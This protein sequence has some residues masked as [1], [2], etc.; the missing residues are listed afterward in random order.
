MVGAVTS[1]GKLAPA[2]R[3]AWETL[4]RAY[5]DF[6]RRTEPDEM[7]ETKWR[8]FLDD[9]RVHALGARLDGRLVGIAHFFAHPSTSGPDVC[10]LQDLFTAAEARGRGVGRALIAAVADWAGERGLRRLYWHTQATNTTARRLYDA[11]AEETGFIVYRLEVAG[12][13]R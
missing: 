8:E 9:T 11:V 6:Y 4:F 7:Y 12:D 1:I 5:I 3:A 13:G 10:Y 2:D